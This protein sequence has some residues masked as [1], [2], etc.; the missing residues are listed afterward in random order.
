MSESFSLEKNEIQ[1]QVE[2]NEG[3]FELVWRRFRRSP[4]SIVG[5]LLVVI[6]FLLSLF[7]EFFSVGPTNKIDLNEA[8]I[9]PQSV[10]FFDSKGQFHFVPF[11]YALENTIDVKTFR[12]TWVENTDKIYNLKFFVRSWKY[13]FLGL[14]ETDLH[15][16]GVEEGGT[17]YMLGTDKLGRDLFGKAAEAGRVS[18]SM[19]LFGT[20]I[21]IA[22]GS[23]VG[24]S[25]G[26]YG[27][28]IDN[29]MQRFVEFINAFPQLPLWMALASIVLRVHF[30][31]VRM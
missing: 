17:L 18:L 9:P 19:S 28:G 15:L 7:S 10:H 6:L 3:Y 23:V 24:I 8:F 21:S 12:V 20:I 25:S 27:G 1:S 2:H 13:E 30:Q 4:A 22:V 11:V 14:F 31:N 26:Y 16:I 5:G 29:A